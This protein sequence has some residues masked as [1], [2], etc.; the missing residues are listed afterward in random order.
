MLRARDRI[1]HTGAGA[2]WLARVAILALAAT[3][4][5]VP[6]GILTGA[7]AAGIQPRTTSP[8]STLAVI[9]T[10]G[11]F[12]SPMGVAV[13]DE[14]DTVYV[15]NNGGAGS[16]SVINGRTG[17][18]S[19]SAITVGT[20]PRGVAVDQSDDTVYVVNNGSNNVSVIDGRTGTVSGSPITVGT[21]PRGVAV[22]QG[23]DTV[24]VTNSGGGSGGGTMSVI[25]GRTGAVSG[26]AVSTMTSAPDGVA[27]DQSDDTVYVASNGNSFLVQVNGRTGQLIFVTP[28]VGTTPR[29]VAVD[30]N[31]DTIYVANAGS[32]DTS[33]INGRTSQR[34][35]T[36]AV[37]SG[38]SGIAVDQGDDTVYVT[39]SNSHNVSVI[40]GRTS[41]RTDDTIAVGSTPLGIAVDNSGTNAGLIYVANSGSNTVDVIGRVTPSLTPASAPAGSTA[42]I[43]VTVPNLASG[44]AMANSAITSVSF[45]GAPATGLTGGAGDTWTVTVPAGT[46]TVPVTVTFD[47]GRSASAGDFTY[48][49]PTPT[50]PPAPTPASAP[51]DVTATAGDAA[52]TVIWKAPASSGDY[53][54]TTYKAVSS[55]GGRTCLVAAPALTCEVTGLTGGTSYTFTVQALTGAGWGATSSPSNAVTPTA[56]PPPSITITGSRDGQRIVVTGTAT[57]LAGKTLRPWRRLPGQATYTEGNAIITPAADGTFTWSRKTGKTA[58][59]YIAH[60]TTRSNI[61]IIPA[62]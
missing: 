42:T 10:I 19:G 11:G 9:T 31:D 5:T 37:G 3:T 16:V 6:I 30:Q 41:Q 39:N 2:R 17:T 27:V 8:T 34:T 32:N 58:Y 57:E 45:G 50:P 56:P 62:R 25:N 51:L 55:P 53:P 14:D 49:S 4:L 28:P 23:D 43:T 12:N 60:G 46:G 44:V 24:Y 29:G 15:T 59:V 26:S 18:V 1:G 20:S 47:G 40:N 38:P 7:E 48:G 52:A 36:I 13:N 61:V 22:D 35:A 54:I 33:V 21:S